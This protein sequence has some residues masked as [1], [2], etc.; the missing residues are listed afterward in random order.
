MFVPCG[1]RALALACTKLRFGGLESSGPQEPDILIVE[2]MSFIFV[3]LLFS[4]SQNN[5]S[6]WWSLVSE[7]R[8]QNLYNNHQSS[9]MASGEIPSVSPRRGIHQLCPLWISTYVKH[10]EYRCA[11]SHPAISLMV[12]TISGFKWDW[13]IRGLHDFVKIP[14]STH[15]VSPFH[16]S[17]LSTAENFLFP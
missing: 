15:K 7:A 9:N 16:H 3:P 2:T 17:L 4:N 6:S 1:A 8:L 14:N 13:G 5:K 12:R 11:Q 10:F